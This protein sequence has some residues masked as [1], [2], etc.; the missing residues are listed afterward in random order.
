[1]IKLKYNEEYITIIEYPEALE[2]IQQLSDKY[3]GDMTAVARGGNG[4][5]KVEYYNYPCSFDIET[6]TIKPGELDYTGTE[7]DPPIAFPYLFQF[8]IYGQVIFCRHYKEAMQIFSW[9]SEYFRLGGN[10]KLIFFD[11]NL[12]YEWHFFRDLW[13]IIPEKCFALDEHHPVTIYTEDGFVFR[14]AY[15][16]TN[17]SLET[18]TKDWSRKYIKLKEIM[19]YSQLRTPYTELDENTMLYSALD[20]LSLSDAIEAFLSARNEKIWTR[21][22]TATSFIRAELKKTIGIGAKQRTEEQH[23]YFDYLKRQRID[24]EQYK[25]LKRLARGGNTHANRAITGVLL[26]DLLHYDITS[27]YPAQMVCYPEFPLGEWAPM[28]PGSYLETVELFESRGYCCMFD[29]ALIN[30]RLKPGVTVP[31]ISISKMVIVE[32]SGMKMTDNGR[33]LGGIKTLSISI[34]GIEWDIIK[35]QY[36]FDDAIILKGYFTKKGY[37]PDI[38]RNFVLKYYAKKSELK[39]V[40]GSEIEYALSKAACNSIFGL[41][42]TD[43][44]RQKYEFDGADIIQS[45]EEDPEAVLEKYQKSIS[46]F[47][48]Y[49]VGCMVAA[50][51]RV[52]L[53]KMID[54]CIDPVTGKSDFSYCDTDSIFALKSSKL[55]QKMIKLNKEITEYQRECGL[56]LVYNDIKGRPHELGDISREQDIEKMITYGAKKYAT[57]ENGELNLTVAGVPKKAGSRLL[58]SIENFKL[59]FNFKGSETG[60]NC[61][62][63]NPD[64]HMILHDQGR[65]IEIY[66]NVAMLPCDYLLSMSRDYLECLSVDGNFHWNFK[67]EYKSGRVNEE[68]YAE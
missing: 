18:L 53:Q 31:Y 27:S 35:R 51:G 19:D 13:K 65:P 26:E 11:M 12:N 60:K 22:P 9:I 52:Y 3:A 34:F 30:A 66:S 68:D 7:E 2:T 10:R 62:W 38:I 57:V 40:A 21:C 1:M 23:R 48:P 41:S 55:E 61:L 42:F 63:Y 5:N 50:L 32:G 28:D 33:Y 4:R 20:V 36:D 58:G 25:M 56:Q 29:V 46:Y 15:K 6:T 49:A 37:L 44:I 8:N 14:D 24:L 54:A 39:G 47:L 64:P 43:I 67:E 16:M 59:G 17:M 45:A